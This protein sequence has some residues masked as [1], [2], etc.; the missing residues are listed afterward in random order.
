MFMY[1]CAYRRS[2]RSCFK[3]VACG[4]SNLLHAGDQTCCMRAI[5]L[6][7]NWELHKGEYLPILC[8]CVRLTF[9]NIFMCMC[10]YR[11]LKT[12]LC[13]CVHIDFYQHI[14]VHVRI[15]TFTNIFMYMLCM[16]KVWYEHPCIYIYIYIYTYIYIYIFTRTVRTFMHTYTQDTLHTRHF[17]IQGLWVVQIVFILA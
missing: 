15:L 12:H 13:T 7:A 8:A 9:T 1:M 3:L 6:V 14:Y 5:K 10:P 2:K 11:R 4:Q 16:I 17:Q